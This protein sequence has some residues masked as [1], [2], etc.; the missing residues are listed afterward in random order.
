MSS[1]DKLGLF[2]EELKTKNDI[3]SVVSKYVPL[4]RKG[5]LFW[6]RCPFHGEKTPSLSIN[7]IDN[8]FYCYGCHVGGNVIEFI[9]RIETI[10]FLDAVKLL[11]S[12]ANI[13]VPDD[14]THNKSNEDFAKAKKRKDRLIALMKDTARHYIDN[15]KKPN[16]TSAL[17]YMKKR[18]LEGKI[19]TH[20]AIGYSDGYN[21][22]PDYLKSLGYTVASISSTV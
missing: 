3:V 2:I 20:F 16:A 1:Q 13:D 18:Q 15:L 11:A 21:D 5:R 6:G 4:D 14:L 17:E 10:E 12:W 8:M 22:L 19:A 7:D 9:K